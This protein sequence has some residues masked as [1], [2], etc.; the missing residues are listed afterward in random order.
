MT[1]IAEALRQ[2]RLHG[3]A[4]YPNSDPGHQG[5]VRVIQ[6]LSRSGR[7]T[8][9]RS[10]PREDYLRLCARSA[11]LLGNS[12]SGVIESAALGI[13]A[14]NIGDRQAGRLRCGKGVL[15]AGEATASIVAAIR[16][17]M[18]RPITARGRSVYGDGQAG[19][20]M[21][22]ILERLIISPDLLRKELTF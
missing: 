9:F 20:K 16:K 1:H 13:P 10:L 22:R 8:A 11:L 18:R 2:C 4:I 6:K 12:S 14:V 7:W 17:A 15:D 19:R 21:V 5:I 3:I